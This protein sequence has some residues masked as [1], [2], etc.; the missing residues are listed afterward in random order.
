[1]LGS[2]FVEQI[3]RLLLG[4]QPMD[5]LR[6]Q[7][8][9]HALDVR[10][11]PKPWVDPLTDE[12]QRWLRARIASGISLSDLWA[13]ATRHATSRYTMRYD[14]ELNAFLDVRVLDASERIVPRRLRIPLAP[15]GLPNDLAVLDQTPASQRT[16]QPSFFPG[17]TYDVSDR[18]TGLR[19]RVVVSD[20]GMPAKRRPV[21]WPRI[22]ARLSNGGP[23]IAWA[24]GDQHGEF[25]LVLP[26]ESIAQPAVQ[27]PATLTLDVTAHGRRMLPGVVPPVLV[28]QADPMW[29]LPLEVLA[30]PNVAPSA[31]GVASGRAI[32]ADYNGVRT[33]TVVFTYA[34]VISNGI[35]PFDIT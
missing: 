30:A 4:L 20:G 9:A 10:V 19:G 15:L 18:V 13:R 11:E 26:P 28:R 16:R 1:M 17:A 33:Q 7:R 29:D 25:L 14:G 27:L 3:D 32:P 35:L 6:A 23:I 22:E 5:A 2:R 12:Q 34:L 8:M 24:H 31:D 21:R